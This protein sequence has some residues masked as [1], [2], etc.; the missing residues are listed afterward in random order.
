MRKL[1]ISFY[2]TMQLLHYADAVMIPCKTLFSVL[3]QSLCR[4]HQSK[5]KMLLNCVAQSLLTSSVAEK[6]QKG[7]KGEEEIKY[8]GRY[9][10][11]TDTDLLH[12]RW[13]GHTVHFYQIG[14]LL[15]QD[16]IQFSLV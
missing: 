12:A 16:H 1:F 13:W 8:Q 14:V 3:K 6:R 9:C 7:I 10:S 15:I 2:F 5:K 4:L 11:C